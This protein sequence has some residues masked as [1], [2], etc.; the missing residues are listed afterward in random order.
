MLEIKQEYLHEFKFSQSEVLKFAELTGDNNPVH[1]DDTYASKTI[2]KRPVIHGMLGAS[3]FSKIFGTLF[4]GEGTIYLGQ[5]LNFMRP[6][7]PDTEYEAVLI[8]KEV[9]KD[10]HKAV[11]ETIIKDKLTGK[12]CTSGEA[13]L[14]NVN[15]I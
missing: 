9:L 1:T 8:V 3:I 15:K 14:Y 13:T 7:Y 2:F 12:I 5:N 4:P 6:M 10:K 11:I